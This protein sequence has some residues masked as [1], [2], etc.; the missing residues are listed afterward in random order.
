MVEDLKNSKYCMLTVL[1]YVDYAHVIGP[2][3]MANLNKKFRSYF[4]DKNQDALAMLQKAAV[5]IVVD[6]LDRVKQ[7]QMMNLIAYKFGIEVSVQ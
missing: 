4:T 5:T 7:L 3:L 2:K 1:S 6:S